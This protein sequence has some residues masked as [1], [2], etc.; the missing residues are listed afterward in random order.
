MNRLVCVGPR[1]VVLLAAL[2]CACRDPVDRAAKERIFSPEDPPKVV[3]S[4][5]E[6]LPPERLAEDSRVARRVLGMGAAETTERLGP[7]QYSAKVSFEWTGGRTVKLQEERTL[8]AGPGGVNGDFHGILDSSRDQGLEVM[9]VAGAVYARSRHGKFRQRLRDRGMAERKREELFGALK[10]F[11]ALF[12]GRLRLEGGGTVVHEGRTAWQ[13]AV[14]LA[15]APMAAAPGVQ[16][17]PPVEPKGGQDASTRRRLLFFEKRQPTSLTGEVLVDAQ[18]SVVLRARLDGRL[19]VPPEGE[20]EKRAEVR[21]VLDASVKNIGQDPALEPPKE[22]LPDADKPAG[23]AMALERFG[24][25]RSTSPDGGTP[26]A[27]SEPE[28]EDEGGQ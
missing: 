11:D 4:A 22:F 20:Q 8:L 16:L 1:A 15:Q 23:I 9:R 5:A 2:V 12:Q 18:T 26:P 13:Y 10:D 24:A 3:A 27:E 17:P 28:P 21:L 19:V 25:V 7:H 14:S 6:A